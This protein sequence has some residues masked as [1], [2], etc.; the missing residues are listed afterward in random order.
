MAKVS[1]LIIPP[2][3]EADYFKTLQ[4]QDRFINSRVTA[5][6]VFSGRKKL[7][8]LTT[9][10]L[11]P[12]IAQLWN[13]LSSGEREAWNSACSLHG[14]VGYKVFIQDVAYRIKYG[15]TYPVA[16]SNFSLY[17]VGKIEI[18]SP[19]SEICLI[20]IHPQS[21][22]IYKKKTGTQ[23]QYDPKLVSENFGLPLELKICYKSDLVATNANPI[24]TFYAEI[25]SSYQGVDRLQA[26]QID[27]DLS[28]SWK[29]ETAVINNI[30]GHYIGYN[31]YFNLQNVRG[32]LLFDN[33]EVNHNA[34]N[35]IRDP[36]CNSISTQ[37]TRQYAQIPDHWTPI[38]QPAGVTYGSIFYEE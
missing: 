34:H 25:V 3:Q 27:L 11:I 12:T 22:Y 8:K 23:S 21:Y 26:C 31:L 14:L 37:F 16:P 2:E 18:N 13:D 7:Q 10:S 15:L 9:K 30:L 28:T 4:P 35:W 17:K 33:L 24:S 19:A 38:I 5:K 6:A 36:N 20:Q 1:T 32:K 29:Q